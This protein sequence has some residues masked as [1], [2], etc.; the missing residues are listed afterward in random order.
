M[1]MKAPPVSKNY[2]RVFLILPFMGTGCWP[3]LV[4]KWVS[5]HNTAKRVESWR[6]GRYKLGLLAGCVKSVNFLDFFFSS[7]EKKMINTALSDAPDANV[8]SSSDERDH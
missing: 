5:G 7:V 8:V 2:M 4:K 6:D 3:C 1:V